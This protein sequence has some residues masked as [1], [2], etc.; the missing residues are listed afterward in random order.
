MNKSYYFILFLF[1]SLISVHTFAGWRS[2]PVSLSGEVNPIYKEAKF[3]GYAVAVI[4]TVTPFRNKI[5]KRTALRLRRATNDGIN[6][7]TTYPLLPN[8]RFSTGI[9]ISKDA[10]KNKLISSGVDILIAINIH[11]KGGINIKDTNLDDALDYM[12][13]LSHDSSNVEVYSRTTVSLYNLHNGDVVW[14]GDGFVKAKPY[15]TKW[16]NISADRL[17]KYLVKL[18]K[19]TNFLYIKRKQEGPGI[20]DF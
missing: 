9:N 8:K 16:F 14:A 1:T 20:D 13:N 7:I 19:K 15:T 18:L 11:N 5:E 3:K 6:I 4:N 2:N 17:A 12:L 10:F